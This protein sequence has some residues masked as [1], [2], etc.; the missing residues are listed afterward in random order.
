MNFLLRSQKMT[1]QKMIRN[2]RLSKIMTQNSFREDAF[3]ASSE[4]DSK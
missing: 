3:A 1:Q 2:L 4:F